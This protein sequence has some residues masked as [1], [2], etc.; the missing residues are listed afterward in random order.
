MARTKELLASHVGNVH[1]QS[2]IGQE[3]TF[4]ISAKHK[5]QFSSMFAELEK[6]QNSLG[7]SSFGM[8][9]T[10]MEEVFLKVGDIAQ[11]RFNASH[12]DTIET[13]ELGEDDPFVAS[14]LHSVPKG[15]SCK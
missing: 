14:K 10:T 5:S 3:A 6:A 12:E 1:L 9:I 4:T 15:K 8:S 13:P 2:L 11:E 7:I